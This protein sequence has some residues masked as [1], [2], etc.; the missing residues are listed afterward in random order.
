VGRAGYANGRIWRLYTPGLEKHKV[1]ELIGIK[2]LAAE[3]DLPEDTLYHWRYVGKGPKC[4][5][6][7]KHLRYRRRDVEAWIDSQ[8]T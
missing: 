7:G 4:A 6:I 8:F 1:S 3:L 2:E 5:K